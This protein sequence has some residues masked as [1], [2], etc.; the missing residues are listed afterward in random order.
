MEPSSKS[1]N[2][3]N[4]QDEVVGFALLYSRIQSAIKITAGEEPR[5]LAATVEF[6]MTLGTE[7]TFMGSDQL[8]NW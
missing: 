1:D 4:L 6:I 2:Q 7:G 8:L 3:S 5:G